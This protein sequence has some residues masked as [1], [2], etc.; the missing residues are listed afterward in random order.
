MIF[1]VLLLCVILPKSIPRIH[2]ELPT[3]GRGAGPLFAI[4]VVA[5]VLGWA[6]GTDSLKSVEL[7]TNPVDAG[8]TFVCNRSPGERYAQAA[9]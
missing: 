4:G 3:V 7:D 2:P 8:G 6:V 5:R 9:S 1:P